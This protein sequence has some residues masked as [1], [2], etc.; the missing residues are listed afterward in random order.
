MPKHHIAMA[1][2]HGCIPNYCDVFETRQGAVESLCQI[3]DLGPYSRF[4]KEL[5]KYGDTEL[6]LHKHGNEYAEIVEC[7]CAEPW[8]HSDSG[9]IEDWMKEEFYEETILKTPLTDDIAG[10]EPDGVYWAIAGELGEI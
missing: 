6:N 2:L 8:V 5:M 7:E 3:H 4:R 10:D 9:K 1:G